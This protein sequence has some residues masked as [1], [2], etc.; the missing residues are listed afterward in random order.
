MWTDNI[1]SSMVILSFSNDLYSTPVNFYFKLFPKKSLSG[2]I[3]R[4]HYFQCLHFPSI[5]FEGDTGR[6]IYK[7]RQGNNSISGCC[8]NVPIRQYCK[9]HKSSEIFSRKLTTSTKNTINF[10]LDTICFGMISTLICFVRE[11]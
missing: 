9:N 8:E 3:A 2:A 5:I 10:F 6:T 11:Y 1:S 7:E 4:T